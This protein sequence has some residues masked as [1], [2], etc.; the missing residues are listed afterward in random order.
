MRKQLRDIDAK[1]IMGKN[2][3][4]KAAILDLQIE[5]DPKKD[6]Y[7]DRK[8]FQ[9]SHKPTIN[10]NLIRDQ[11]IGN[12]GLIFTNGDLTA[13]KEILDTQV[14]GAPAK[15]GAIAPKEVVV[16]PG[17]TG[18][19]PKQTQFF[20][21]LSIQTKIVR[22]QIEIVNAVTVISEGDK[23]SQSQAALLDKLKITPFEYKMVVR[24]F[25]ENGKLFSAKVLDLKDDD[26][27]GFFQAGSQNL[28]CISLATGYVI[29]SATPHMIINAFKNLA[30][31]SIAA[32][33]NFP[34]LE[35]L[36]SAAK[37]APASGGG[38]A[39]AASA[40]AAEAAPAEDEEMDVGGM[41]GLFGGDDDY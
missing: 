39:A 1:M 29:P 31:A 22:A 36:K 5:A 14:R 20:Q 4:F 32:D 19:D 41:D 25:T 23:I 24:A 21:A 10:L 18:M 3:H 9:A 40:P 26:I 33:Y 15:V 7:E 13:V 2:T 35:S 28:T 34:Q 37:A 16:P 11:L 17:P 30:A 27:L 38:G 8:A 12:T 6:D